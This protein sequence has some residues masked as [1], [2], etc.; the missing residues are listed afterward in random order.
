MEVCADLHRSIWECLKCIS[1]QE[2]VSNYLNSV[3][4]E[5]IGEMSPD[6]VGV[7]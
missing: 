6:S 4:V 2:R 7:R 5:L 3:K 1:L